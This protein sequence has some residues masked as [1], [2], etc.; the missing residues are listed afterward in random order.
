MF[1]TKNI[2]WRKLDNTAKIFPA[3][4][5]RRDTR[6]F[7]FYCECE[8]TI[9]S[10]MLQTALTITMEKYPLFQTVLRK[11]FFWFYMEKSSLSPQVKEECDAPCLDL[12]HKDQKNLLFQVTYYEKRI[13]LEVFH[14]LTDGTGALAFLKELVKN[15]LILRYPT[16]NLPDISLTEP[17]ETLQDQE[18]DSFSKYYNQHPT[19]KGEKTHHSYQL[20][21]VKTNY[22]DMNITEGVVSC[23]TLR[24]KAR[25][26]DVSVTV[27]LTSIL[28]LA[29]HEEMP[30]FHKKRPIVLMIPVNLRNF[31][32]SSSMLN[33]WGWIE[34]FYSFAEKEFSFEH[35]L[36]SIKSYFKEELTK[37]SLEWRVSQYMK[38]EKNPIIRLFPL[39]LKNLGM[40]LVVQLTKNEVTAVFSNL[41]IIRLP[42]EYAAHI[43][44]FGAFTST[45]KLEMCT[46]SFE[47]DFVISFTSGF[48]NQNV[49]R[50]FF[51]ILKDYGISSTLLTKQF[52]E[53][54]ESS[55]NGLHFFQWFSF[56]CIAATCICA[57]INFMF[58]PSV[59][60]SVFVAGGAL[61]AWLT[62]ALGLRK[63]HNLL[64]GAVWQILLLSILCVIW[65]FATG[66]HAW[67]VDFAMPFLIL[68]MDA[69]IVII[70]K[71]KN[72]TVEE[73]M[74][75]HIM[76]G[77]LGLVPG[78]LALLQVS[79]IYLFDI[80]CSGISFLWLVAMLIFKWNDF[81]EELHKKLHF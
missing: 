64:K 57:M 11:G 31:F 38:L 74:I 27:L 40:Q 15:Y 81:S 10:S 21:G 50:N 8:D 25:E 63:R 37:E 23:K 34:P 79:H 14:A 22:G 17:D 59:Y 19:K 46:C 72:L 45:P 77:L 32:S 65:D 28:M 49:E 60:W 71:V 1:G 78:T 44:R 54:K 13:N 48:Q 76:A 52:P 75:Y 30:F 36:S 69:A 67:S 26:Y 35:I 62:L 51:R 80:L 47:D 5:N 53:K 24:E 9:D 33:F 70:T 58:T 4:S 56:A 12:Y 55:Q 41:G 29:I 61:S 73:H 6:V 18:T 43:K 7:R 39:E 66:W 42:Q 68:G 20:T 16:E 3:V 2:H